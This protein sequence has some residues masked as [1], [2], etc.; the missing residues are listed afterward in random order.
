MTQEIVDKEAQMAW[1]GLTV[2][3]LNTLQQGL[4]QHA[5]ALRGV[6]EV[7][8]LRSQDPETARYEMLG[9]VEAMIGRAAYFE[10]LAEEL[11]S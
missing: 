7:Q 6:A 5:E 2:G 9:L 3:E 4:M 8:P 1:V 10:R 11:R